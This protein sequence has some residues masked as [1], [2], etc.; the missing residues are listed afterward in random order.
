MAMTVALILVTY[1]H[2]PQ[3]LID[4]VEQSGIKVKWYIHHHGTEEKFIER[5][6]GLEGKIN[7]SLYFHMKNRGLSRSWNDGLIVAY[8]EGAEYALIVNDDLHFV[9]G[10]FAKFIEF[11][12][13]V[14]NLGICYTMGLEIGD[15]LIAGSVVQQGMACAIITP[16]AIG[17]VGY[18]DTNFAPA[19]YEDMDYNLRASRL[20]V[21]IVTHRETLVEHDRSTTTR[22]NPV[23]KE[24]ISDIMHLNRDYF[25]R[26]WNVFDRDYGR[27]G[28]QIPFKTPFNDPRF[29]LHIA[30]E[31]RDNPYPGYEQGLNDK[32]R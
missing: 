31:V 9:D 8:H 32:S 1:S 27:F 13:C 22:T 12:R 26:K 30:W 15:S 21:V 19:Y 7:V 28:G 18:F 24:K 23:I 11:A 10:G 3:K 20:D 6:R 14:D 4:S 17:Q 29:G 16:N 25:E 2:W 5:L